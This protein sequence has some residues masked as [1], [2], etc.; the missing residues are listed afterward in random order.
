[1]PW[2]WIIIFVVSLF[3]LVKSADWLIGSA[4]KIGLAVG[5]SPFIIGVT[6]VSLGT[7]FPEVVASMMATFRGVM[8]MAVANA[9]G[10]NVANIL[11]VVGISAVIG[12]RLTFSQSLIDLELPL[13]AIG[14]VL[15]IGIAWNGQITFWE[16]MLMLITYIVYLLHTVLYKDRESEKTDEIKE[17]LPGR[18]ERRGQVIPSQ[19]EE[20][21]KKPKLR[22][23]DF[24]FLIGGMVGLGVGSHYLIDSLIELSLLMG[25]AT[26]VIAATAVAFG[27]SLPELMV[28]VKAAFQKKPEVALGNIFGSNVFNALVVVGLPGLF[29]TLEVDTQTL[30]IGLPIMGAA[31]LLFVI[32]GISRRIHIWEGAFYLSLYIFFI[33]KLFGWF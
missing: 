22:T 2:F 8:D 27:T 29:R 16:A 4:E 15:F 17:A 3:M 33:A 24:L 25:V 30:A 32:S 7:S 31:T 23:R 21:A 19:I 28:S 14:T 11:L 6:V 10:S 12:Y 9:V 1:M 13:L 18:P 26:G 5:L 20:K